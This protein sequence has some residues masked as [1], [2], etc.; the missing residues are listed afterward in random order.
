MWENCNITHFYGFKK[1]NMMWLAVNQKC[2]FKTGSYRLHQDFHGH[3]HQGNWT[4]FIWLYML[5]VH[6]IVDM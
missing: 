2:A 3:T 6:F 5:C 4:C 1:P